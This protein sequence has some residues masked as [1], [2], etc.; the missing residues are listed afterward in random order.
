MRARPRSPREQPL[1]PGPGGLGGR[2]RGLPS[3]GWRTPRPWHTAL[4][5]VPPP[6]GRSFGPV[7]EAGP[8]HLWGPAASPPEWPRSRGLYF[9]F[10]PQARGG[11]CWWSGASVV[12]D[13]HPESDTE[14]TLRPRA[15]PGTSL[16]GGQTA[17]GHELPAAWWHSRSESS[18][19]SPSSGHT[20]ATGGRRPRRWAVPG[21][22]RG[23]V[24]CEP[25]EELLARSV[26]GDGVKAPGRDANSGSGQ[27]SSHPQASSAR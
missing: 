19:L 25:H 9:P 1:A 21:P 5:R 27:T 17:P 14:G 26:A 24:W 22:V 10:F 4:G 8:P 13:A 23:A 15:G 12:S 11:A 20:C 6:P 7:R 2:G 18:L 16:H 3:L